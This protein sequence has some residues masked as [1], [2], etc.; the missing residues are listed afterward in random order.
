M[1]NGTATFATDCCGLCWPK[2]ECASAKRCRCSTATGTPDAQSTAT[3][4]VVDRPH[5]YG[6][7]TKSGSRRVHV[8]SRLDRL[9]ADYVW[10]LCD[11]GADALIEDWDTELH[12]LQHDAEN[13]S[14]GRCGTEA[15]YAHLRSVKRRLPQLPAAMTPHWFRHTHATALLLRRHPAACREPTT[16]SPERPDHDQHVRPRHTRM[17][18]SKRSPNWRDVVAGWEADPVMVSTEAT[19]ATAEDKH[20][21]PNRW[22]R[23]DPRLPSGRAC[24]IP[25]VAQRLWESLPRGVPRRPYRYEEHCRSYTQCNTADE[26]RPRGSGQRRYLNLRDLPGDA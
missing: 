26:C 25:L 11:R 24:S 12:I 6:L 8:G 13:P 16:R 15:V 22:D 19:D 1:A 2:P 18:S 14:T 20:R 7:A 17:P 9:Y 21:E 23:R 3:V 4:S 10:W 5:P